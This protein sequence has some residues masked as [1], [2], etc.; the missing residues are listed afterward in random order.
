MIQDRNYF[1]LWVN[2]HG[3]QHFSLLDSSFYVQQATITFT[4]SVTGSNNV[5]S[6]LPTFWLVE[7]SCHIQNLLVWVS[8]CLICP[9]MQRLRF[10]Q[11]R[12]YIH[13]FFP[14]IYSVFHTNTYGAL[15]CIL[16][17]GDG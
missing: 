4:V 10:L 5:H 9:F 8:K 15:C 2:M 12:P 3:S 1:F 17:C 14:C 16:G 6:P 13:S 11:N 7:I